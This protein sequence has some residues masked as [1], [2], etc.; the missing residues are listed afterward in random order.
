[1]I[2]QVKKSV[3]YVVVKM[4]LANVKLKKKRT[5][6]KNNETSEVYFEEGTAQNK[7]FNDIPEKQSLVELIS[8]INEGDI[9]SLVSFITENKELWNNF[10]SRRR[11]EKVELKGADFRNKN[12]SGVDFSGVNLSNSD[13]RGANLSNSNLAYS[14]LGGSYLSQTNLSGSNMYKVQNIGQANITGSA[15]LYAVNINYFGIPTKENSRKP[16]GYMFYGGFDPLRPLL[17]N[18]GLGPSN[19]YQAGY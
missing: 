10:I 19:Y 1:L 12:L 3:K 2:L 14:N 8:L 11:E 4:A 13:F 17:G 5:D 15:N 9:E 7:N 6:Q 18:N 16:K